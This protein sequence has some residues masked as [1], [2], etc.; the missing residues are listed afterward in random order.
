MY[1]GMTEDE[2]RSVYD[3][4]PKIVGKRVGGCKENLSESDLLD[5]I[6]KQ[7]A[8]AFAIMDEFRSTYK[9]WWDLSK[10]FSPDNE[11]KE[12]IVTKSHLEQLIL[13]RD[14]IR[15]ALAS[16]LNYKYGKVSG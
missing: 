9:A 3:E 11:Q 15:K 14:E 2:F 8:T 7:D 13:K 10:T 16:Y 12:F 5:F 1:L 6:K 4:T